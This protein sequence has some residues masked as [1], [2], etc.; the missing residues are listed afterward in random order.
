[1]LTLL[2]TLGFLSTVAGSA[3]A[4]EVTQPAM[5]LANRKGVANLVC[6]YTH[7]GNAREFRV[8]LLKQNSDQYIQICASTYTTEYKMFSVEKTIECHVSPSQNNVTLT[9]MGL[10]AADAGLYICKMERL[11]PPPYYMN[12]GKG[13]QL[14][15]TDPE[16]CPDTDL[17]LWILGASA[18]GF[19]LYSVLIT[20]CVLSKALQ[21][22][23][24]ITTGLY[25]K[26]TSEE[27]EKKVK[28]YHIVIR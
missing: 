23:K 4:M 18:S 22:R 19:F 15:V 12:T 3:K 5:V 27:E 1:M 25:V 28:P 9:L 17:Y 13:T 8:T 10:Q 6:E 11:F 20:A 21:K 16:P 24:Y 2:T 26:M 14:F 7:V